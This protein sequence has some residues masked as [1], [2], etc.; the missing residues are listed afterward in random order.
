MKELNRTKV[1]NFII[2]KSVKLL[3]LETSDNKD[4]YI[5]QVEDICDNFDKVEFDERN[6]KL[7]LNGVKLT[8]KLKDGIYRV[9][10]NQKFVGL[11][12]VKNELIKRD[13]II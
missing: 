1:D 13:V 8:I 3:E 7:F 10:N 2:E 11:G 4:K 9:Y 12:I 6:L 5:I